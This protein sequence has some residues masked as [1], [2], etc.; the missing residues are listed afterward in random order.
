MVL[1]QRY[2]LCSVNFRGIEGSQKRVVHPPLSV[3]LL[4]K[5]QTLP[6]SVAW[7]II[8]LTGISACSDIRQFLKPLTEMSLNIRYVSAS[9]GDNHWKKRKQLVFDVFT[10]HAPDVIGLEEALD[11]QF[12]AILAE[13]P[14]FASI[15]IGRGPGGQGEH[16][17]ILSRKD[18]FEI[19]EQDTS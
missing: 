14:Q 7:S 18:R 3:F 5:N 11:F 15:G 1:H 6:R 2:H 19:L 16:C 4:T 12:D 9:D 13:H 17:A 10:N 8:L